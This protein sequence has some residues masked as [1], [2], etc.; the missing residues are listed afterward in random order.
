MTDFDS[1]NETFLRTRAALKWGPWDRDVISLSV[2]D[3]DFPAPPEIKE[4]VVRAAREDRTPYGAYGGDPDVLEVVCEKINRV[5]RIPA[6][7]D[8]VHMIPGTMFAIF[9]TLSLIHI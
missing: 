8:D 3:M 5:N 9:L 6:T 7:P 2:A 4:A 1:I